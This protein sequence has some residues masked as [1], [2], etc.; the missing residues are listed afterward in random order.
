[1]RMPAMKP[2]VENKCDH[3]GGKLIQRKDDE[4]VSQFDSVNCC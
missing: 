1:M 4:L 3:C 2:K